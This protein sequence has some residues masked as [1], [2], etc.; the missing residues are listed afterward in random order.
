ME[1]DT[2]VPRVFPCSLKCELQG[3]LADQLSALNRVVGRRSDAFP[4]A[5]PDEGPLRD[6]S[7]AFKSM[8]YPVGLMRT[9]GAEPEK[10][11]VEPDEIPS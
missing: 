6:R 11:R 10:G 2:A 3:G 9:F 1:R 4:M 5:R 8:P 7:K